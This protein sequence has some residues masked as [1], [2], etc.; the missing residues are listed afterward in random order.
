MDGCDKRGRAPVHGNLLGVIR[1]ALR[2][3]GLDPDH[4]DRAFGARLTGID[5]TEEFCAAA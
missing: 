1:D 3:A 2:S 4:L 5:A